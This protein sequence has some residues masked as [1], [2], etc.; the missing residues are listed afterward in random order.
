MTPEQISQHINGAGV[1]VEFVFLGWG[2]IYLVREASRR[3]LTIGR[4]L[5]SLPPGMAFVMAVL[6][7]D[8]GVGGRAAIIWSWRRYYDSGP[9]TPTQSA[10]LELTAALI[11]LG[12]L[13]KIRAVTRPDYGPFPWLACAGGVLV[14][15]FLL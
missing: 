2:V 5:R 6:L 7:F 4:W 10:F 14:L 11:V 15:F 1:F 3:H 8:I 9:F 13:A 12:G